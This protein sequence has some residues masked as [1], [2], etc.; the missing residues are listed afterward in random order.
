[1]VFMVLSL[2][3]IPLFVAMIYSDSV[4]A[5]SLDNLFYLL[6]LIRRLVIEKPSVAKVIFLCNKV[7]SSSLD[8]NIAV[9]SNLI[10]R[11]V[12]ETSLHI[13]G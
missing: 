3:Y 8:A 10:E 12:Y 11:L 13:N 4:N 5:F 9:T 7:S 1:M 6:G 2:G